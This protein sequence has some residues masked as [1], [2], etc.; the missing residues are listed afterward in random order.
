MRKNR[1][2]LIDEESMDGLGIR[3]IDDE[4]IMEFDY[5][6]NPDTLKSFLA[7]ANKNSRLMVYRNSYFAYILSE[8]Y[9]D[10]IKE[11]LTEFLQKDGYINEVKRLKLY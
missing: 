4:P 9:D 8:G 11:I 3:K 2:S 7:Q 10:E 1:N 5:S 6:K